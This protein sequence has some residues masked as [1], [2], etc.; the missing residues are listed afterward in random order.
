MVSATSLVTANITLKDNAGNPLGSQ[1]V[2]VSYVP[3]SGGTATT[4]GSAITTDPTGAG[5]TSGQVNAPGTYDF[6][7]TFAGVPGQYPTTTATQTGVQ[8]TA[9][10]LLTLSIVVA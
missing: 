9:G 10:V 6:T 8:V 7:A 2:T 4:L 3:S 5:T 1:Q